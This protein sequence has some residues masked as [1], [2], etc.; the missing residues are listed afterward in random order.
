MGGRIVFHAFIVD[1]DKYAAEATYKMFPWKELNVSHVVQIYTPTGLTE[2]I[3]TEKP[4]I[5]FI[6]IEMG[7][8]SG[9]EIIKECQEKNVDSIF[10]II[11]GHDNFS[12]AHTAVNIGAFYYLL[13]PIGI[14]DVETVTK[15]LKVALSRHII[16]DIAEEEPQNDLWSKMLDYIEKN[17]TKKIQV[18]DI[19]QKL[20]ISPTTFY[21]V[22]KTNANETFIEY[23]THF[24]L[25]KAKT[26]LK[27]TQL[28]IPEIAEA[29][30]I[31]DHYYFNKIFKR[32]THVTPQKYRT[33]RGEENK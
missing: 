29:V 7:N 2:R 24:R 15:K 32:H 10:I 18:Q 26:L 3:L 16:E 28:S 19:C 8:V 17:Y 25:D 31:K 27:T 14:E 30:G 9:L 11:S 4:N 13:K 1:D 21:N 22:F 5:V 12:Y 20:L 6:D 33:Q 23:L